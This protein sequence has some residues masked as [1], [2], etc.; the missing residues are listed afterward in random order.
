MTRTIHPQ[1]MLTRLAALTLVGTG[2]LTCTPAV[3]SAAPLPPGDLTW[4]PHEATPGSVVD[5]SFT[6]CNEGEDVLVIASTSTGG[7]HE[8]AHVT[9]RTAGMPN[10]VSF[11]LDDPVLVPGKD[12]YFGVYCG[13][14]WTDE[15][16][17]WVRAYGGLIV[18]PTTPE[19]TVPDDSIP[20][21]TVPEHTVPEH[22]VPEHTTVPTAAD[23]ATSGKPGTEVTATR[24]SIDTAA[25]AAAATAVVATPTYTG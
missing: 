19:D 2:W 8:E 22:T 16:G 23:A 13:G 15:A 9:A 25:P 11:T 6:G 21:H 7:W 4:T 24:S 17:R 3:V 18:E 20:E 12:F 5:V 1:R 10:H 14:T